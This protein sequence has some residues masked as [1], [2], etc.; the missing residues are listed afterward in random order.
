VVYY[1]FM[2]NLIRKHK[3]PFVA[4]VIAVIL[5][6]FMAVIAVSNI[7]Y[8]DNG[9]KSQAGR[10]VTIYD[11]G[12]EK[13]ILTQSATIGDALKESGIII[14]DKDLVEPAVGEK[15][16]A[17]S[18]QVNIYRARPVLVIDGNIRQKIITPYQ[19]A[20]QITNSAGIVLYP[21]DLTTI[22]RVDNL[23]DGAGLQ[24][25]IK[26]ATAFIF[27]LY[28]K[29]TV[30]RTQ[31]LTIGAMLD[32]K[33][34][35]LST[36]DRASLSLDTKLTEN[37]AVR[38]WREGKQTVTTDVDINFEVQKIQ[39]ADRE[40]GYHA[41]TLVGEKGV[42]SVTYEVLIQDGQEVSRTEIASLTIK[43]PVTQVEV[44]GA[45]YKIYGGTCSDWIIG[46]GI[47]DLGSASELIRR[48]SNC[49][50]Y[51]VNRTSGAC[52]VG[53]ALPCSKTGCEMGDGACQTIWM[54]QY[55]LGRYGSWSA[56][57]QH[58]YSYG[59]Y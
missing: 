45:K 12:T 26:R 4:L 9:D 11:R 23:T 47:T 58:S 14:D 1:E 19:T 28:G 54:N 10:L 15:L 42:R 52:G 40:I 17:S 35:K 48:E 8:A 46:A 16:I 50:P 36:D 44:I 37:L 13:V 38:V 51:S 43:N 5:L 33:G 24:L 22:D 57:L 2:N 6:I 7:T 30:V 59:W 39:D 31:A 21:E 18:Y 27:T 29:T 55:V 20:Q 49:N 25:T 32:E 53:Q 3:Q 56:A 34:I 41:V